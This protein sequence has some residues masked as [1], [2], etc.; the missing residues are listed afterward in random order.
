M[1]KS[2]LFLLAV[3]FIASCSSPKYTYNFDHYNY[4]SG[5]KQLSSS[6]SEETGPFTLPAESVTASASSLPV[7]VSETP[8]AE[9][10]VPAS[11]KTKQYIPDETPSVL[12]RNY[13]AMS[14]EERKEFRKELKK[15]IKTYAKAIRKGDH[16]AATQANGNLDEDLRMAIIFGAIGLV[17]TL[18]GGVSEAF[19]ILGVI[20]IIIGVYFLI[21]WLVRQ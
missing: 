16:V 18:F 19:W 21:R 4:N 17:L 1:K 5:K 7:V 3:L 8:A 2:P 13:K 20:G 10:H 11:T 6:P 14:R 9:K 12:T 15:E